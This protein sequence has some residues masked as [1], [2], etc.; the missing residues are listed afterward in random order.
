MI[1]I[2]YAAV[3]MSAVS[4]IAF[5]PKIRNQVKYNAI[6]DD[7]LV[8]DDD[9]AASMPVNRGKA[10][11]K[12]RYNLGIGKHSPLPAVKSTISVNGRVGN[13]SSREDKQKKIRD[14]VHNK[15]DETS[16]ILAGAI[17]EEQF[18]Y[19]DTE[20]LACDPNEVIEKN[21]TPIK[22]A[23]IHDDLP[24]SPEHQKAEKPPVNLSTNHQ[25]GFL[26]DSYSEDKVWD[27]MRMEARREAE[28]EPLLVSFL[29]S[30]ILN[31]DSLESALAFHLANRLASP[32]MISTQVMNLC[33][34]ALKN[35]PEF[36]KSLRDDIIAVRER[37]PACTCLPDVLL[38]F[39]GFHALQTHRVANYL[40]K[41][42]R[43]VLAHYLQSQMSQVYQIDI[44]PNATLG[45]GIMLDHGT[46]IVIGE[47]AIVGD[48]CS[49]LHHVTL[50]GSGKKN[51][52]RHPKVGDG[53]LIGAG[54][55]VLGNVRIGTG[56][57]IGAGS[58]VISDLPDFSVAVGV[59]AKIIGEFRPADN[60]STPASKMNQLGID[61]SNE[62]DIA[63]HSAEGI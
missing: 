37:D 43:H 13:A 7:D 53:V 51:V 23:T 19:D 60:T 32:S 35:S 52:D 26:E 24:P 39:K 46:G 49:I 9:Q 63:Y 47:T 8:D 21:S 4:F 25:N 17:D 29:F 5:E 62:E 18:A 56:A 27:V 36:R 16:E 57:Q 22:F 12:P 61:G 14:F 50:G 20:G 6:V 30:T 3:L 59:P 45:S 34:E 40:W 38:Y 42:G 31:H 54:A 41:S 28:R 11:K 33:L 58:L 44:H 55:S 10:N 2:L 15:D 48:N 1:L